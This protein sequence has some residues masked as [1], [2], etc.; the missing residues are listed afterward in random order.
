MKKFFIILVLFFCIVLSACKK[1]E[2][3]LKTIKDNEIFLMEES[4]YYIFFSKD[5]C[6]YCDAARPEI[7]SYLEQINS[8]SKKY[9]NCRTV[10]EVSLKNEDWKS[11]ISRSYSGTGG[12]GTD[13]KFYVN[14]VTKWDSLYIATTPS[15][16]AIYEVDGVRK[17]KYLA[18]TRSGVINYLKETLE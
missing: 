1:D 3:L 18:Q 17:A 14:G 12:Q 9:K 8:N 5:D 2:E 7:I 6:K 11:E 4:A 13:D 15:L 10:Y 16:I